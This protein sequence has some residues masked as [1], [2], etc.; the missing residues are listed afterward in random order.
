M[1]LIQGFLGSHILRSEK[2]QYQLENLIGHGGM[3]S[4]YKAINLNSNQNKIPEIVAI[5]VMVS[6]LVRTSADFERF[7]R[8]AMAAIRLD[9]PNI[10]QV[11][12]F[13]QD[14]TYHKKA[15]MC[16]ELLEG[17]TLRDEI[18]RNLNTPM[19]V[20]KL[21][22]ILKAIASALDAAHAQQIIHRDIKPENILLLPQNGNN[23]LIKVVDFGIAK[24][25][26]PTSSGQPLTAPGT[27]MGTP[28]YMSPEQCQEHSLDHKT[29]IY[30]LA[31]LAYECLTGGQMP[32]EASTPHEIL[33]K[34]VKSLPRPIRQIRPDL[35]QRIEAVLMRGLSKRPV[36]RQESATEFALEFEKA[37]RHQVSGQNQALKNLNPP[38]QKSD[39]KKN[40]L[41]SKT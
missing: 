13:S 9:H 22:F 39:S 19:S 31:A 29:D 38:S 28:N 26:D 2:T 15:F 12:D 41:T 37:V 16:M 7:R 30:S 20:R 5:K 10:V 35:H 1:P 34:H 32:F 33:L 25:K 6:E 23:P 11:Y 27:V 14:S 8:E 24:L 21:A 18:E 36:D 3:A 40:K 4:V 17:F